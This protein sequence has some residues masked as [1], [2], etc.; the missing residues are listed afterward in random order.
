MSRRGLMCVAVGGLLLGAPTVATGEVVKQ[1]GFSY[2]REEKQIGLLTT[3][4]FT[5]RCPG[6]TH[7]LSGGAGGEAIFGEGFISSSYPYDGG[8]SGKT[9]DDGWKT[10]ISSFDVPF[11]VT[12]TAVCS[13]L[14]P[15]YRTRKETAGAAPGT[16]IGVIPC[17]NR[18]IVHGGL[19]APTSLRLVSSFPVDFPGDDNWDLQA[20]N[21]SNRTKTGTGYAV[22]SDELTV[23]YVSSPSMGVP[24]DTQRTATSLCP[25]SAPNPIGGGPLSFGPVGGM[26]LSRISADPPDEWFATLETVDDDGSFSV[27]ANCSPDL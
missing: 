20:D 12:P 5:A 24:A 22:C 25:P 14:T 21:I 23:T 11:E 7:V 6:R 10:K 26:R 9:P 18:A 2:V 13:R 15:T 16:A 3:K 27:W 4:T 1:G 8:D 17:G 19:R